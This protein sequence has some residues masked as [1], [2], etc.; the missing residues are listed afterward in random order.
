MIKTA[1]RWAFVLQEILKYY[2]PIIMEVTSHVFLKPGPENLT[3]K[4]IEGRGYKS[5]T[6]IERKRYN[7]YF[8]T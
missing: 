5:E 2:N 6:A 3:R 7:I 4:K 1:G 8:G